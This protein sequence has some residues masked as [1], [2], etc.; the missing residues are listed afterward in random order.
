ML[1]GEIVDYSRTHKRVRG[2]NAMQVD[3]VH[4]IAWREWQGG[5]QKVDGRVMVTSFTVFI[6]RNWV[7][8]GSG[9]MLRSEVS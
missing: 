8:R 7:K 3:A 2:P 4:M 6:S 5:N 9:E 1:R